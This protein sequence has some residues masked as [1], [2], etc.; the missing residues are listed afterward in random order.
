MKIVVSDEESSLGGF[1]ISHEQGSGVVVIDGVSVSTEL[2]RQMIC[3]PNPKVWLRLERVGDMVNVE[4][5]F[6]E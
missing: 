3:S 5:R 1:E 4:S 6:A 2:L